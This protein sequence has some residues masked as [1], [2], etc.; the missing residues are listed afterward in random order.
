MFPRGAGVVL[1]DSYELAYN[2]TFDGDNVVFDMHE[3][4]IINDGK[5]ALILGQST[6]N[7]GSDELS[8]LDLPGPRRDHA[9]R[10]VDFRTRETMF[11]WWSTAGM[12][13]STMVYPDNEQDD[14]DY[15]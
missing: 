10:E 5:S 15:M 3:F 13:D 6:K 12:A 1:D 4:N 11:E 8:P 9:A 2:L 14:W 7:V